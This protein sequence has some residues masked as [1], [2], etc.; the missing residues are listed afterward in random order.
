MCDSGMRQHLLPFFDVWF[1][2]ERIYGFNWSLISG[3]RR[4]FISFIVIDCWRKGVR[5]GSY[6]IFKKVEKVVDFNNDDYIK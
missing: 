6:L 3:V 1:I 5:C 4:K 2:V